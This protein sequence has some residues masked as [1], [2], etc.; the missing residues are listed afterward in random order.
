MAAAAAAI[1]PLDEVRAC[2]TVAGFGTNHDRFITVHSITGMDDFSFMDPDEVAQIMKMYNDRQTGANSHRKLG[3][4]VLKKL[5]GFLY[6]YH[7]KQRRQ[8]VAVAAEF[9]AAALSKA[10]GD[11]KVESTSKDSEVDMEVGPIEIEMDWWKWKARF[12]AA[13]EN[14]TGCDGI[15]LARVIREQKP[16]GWTTAQATSDIERLIYQAS[17]TGDAYQRDNATVWAQLQKSTMEHPVYTWIRSFDTTK[18]GR[19]GYLALLNY[20]EGT[21]QNNKRLQVAVRLISGPNDGGLSYQNEYSGFTFSKYTTKLY[22]AYEI[23]QHER[24]ETA[25][26]TMVERMLKGI[27]VADSMIIT[28][29]KSHVMDHLLGNWTGAVQYMSTKVSQEFPPRASGQKRKARDQRRVSQAGRGRDGR[30]RG[31]GRGGR[32]GRGR[33]RGGRHYGRGGGRGRGGAVVFNNVDVSEHA[34]YF[35]DDEMTRMGRDG[36]EYI[37]SRRGHRTGD[38][39]GRGRGDPRHENDRRH[40]DEASVVSEITN[41]ANQER[42][43]VPWSGDRNQDENSSASHRSAQGRG[44]QAGRGF[45]RGMYGRGGRG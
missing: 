8:Q 33:G 25:P 28:M 16:T 35:T 9:N 2:L 6:W 36:R 23:I 27:L 31:R 24:N 4:T 17:L 15:P 44:G 13:M 43:L 3:F 5:K 18:D 30:G 12:V 26:E 45:G 37:Q 7:D 32:D 20:C 10:L 29:A 34:R 39:P 40:V 42:Q 11:L 14:K 22:D 38:G 1:D 19:G 21:A 41:Q